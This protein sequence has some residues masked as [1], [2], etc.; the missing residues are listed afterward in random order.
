MRN[1]DLICEAFL[2]WL[3]K[4][5]A[6][7]ANYVD[8]GLLVCEVHALAHFTSHIDRVLRRRCSS[9]KHLVLVFLAVLV[10]VSVG[11]VLPTERTDKFKFL[12]FVAISVNKTS[13]F[14]HLVPGLFVKFLLIV[15]VLALELLTQ[16]PNDIILELQKFP[17]F[18]IMLHED[19]SFSQ[20]SW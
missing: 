3:C 10:D 5:V 18:F 19:T 7:L 16:L 13:P 2:I 1:T 15:V 11:Q 6:L 4:E 14:V 12:E 17:L 20:L 8:W 9:S